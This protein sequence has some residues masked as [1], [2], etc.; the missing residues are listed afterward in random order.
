MCTIPVLDVFAPCVARSRLTLLDDSP[1]KYV[2]RS[3][4]RLEILGKCDQSQ[5]SKHLN[6]SASTGPPSIV[7]HLYILQTNHQ[8][9]V[10]RETPRLRFS[11]FIPACQETEIRHEP[12][13]WYLCGRGERSSSEWRTH[14][15]GMSPLSSLCA[16]KQAWS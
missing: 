8:H 4:E 11:R 10:C 14:T 9:H 7:D 15:S 2:I 1:E 16:A 3:T 12:E 5:S 13:Q 6:Q